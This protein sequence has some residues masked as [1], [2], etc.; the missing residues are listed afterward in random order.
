MSHCVII[1]MMVVQSLLV[2]GGGRWTDSKD[3]T[4]SAGSSTSQTTSG[5]NI[6]VFVDVVKELVCVFTRL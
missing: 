3:G 1:D 5:W 2:S 4:E 6:D